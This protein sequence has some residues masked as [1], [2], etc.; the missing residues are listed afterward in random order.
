MSHSPEEK[1]RADELSNQI[2][3]AAIEVHRHLGPGLLE[4]AYQKCL[5]HELTLRNIAF[6]AQVELPIEYK[7]L[8]LPAAYK[9]DFLVE[10]LV[11]LEIKSVARFEPIYDAQ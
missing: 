2:I 11:I 3:N 9:L 5:E 4:S 7:G 8:L 10:E 6:R 1:K